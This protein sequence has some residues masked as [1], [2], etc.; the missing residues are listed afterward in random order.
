MVRFEDRVRAMANSM[1][2]GLGWHAPHSDRFMVEGIDESLKE[3]PAMPSLAFATLER[4]QKNVPAESLDDLRA[5]LRGSLCL[6]GE[7]GYDDAR[8]IWNAMIQCRPAAIV[9][10]A[11][12]A[13]VIRA[14]RLAREHGL[15]LSVRGGG[16]I[17]RHASQRP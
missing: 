16:H 10:A 11:G 3:E 15:L 17:E 5:N 8:T 7:A 12:A 4:G 1:L 9:R 13:D 6:P 2:E 14:V